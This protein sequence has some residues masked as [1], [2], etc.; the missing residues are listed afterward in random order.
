MWQ[1]RSACVLP[2]VCV[3]VHVKGVCK[4]EEL[5]SVSAICVG[6]YLSSALRFIPFD[7]LLSVNHSR[8]D[9]APLICSSLVK[10]KL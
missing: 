8:T 9:A 7:V 2:T 1:I 6:V 5:P 10:G 3:H 4:A